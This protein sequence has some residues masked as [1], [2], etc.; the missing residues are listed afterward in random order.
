MMK[1]AN[2]SVYSN[3]KDKVVEGMSELSNLQCIMVF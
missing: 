2:D 3:N 1:F